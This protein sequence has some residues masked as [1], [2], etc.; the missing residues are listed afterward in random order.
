MLLASGCATGVTGDPSAISDNDALVQGEV[1]SDTG[2]Q[3]EYWFEYGPTPAYGSESVHGTLTAQPNT[4]HPVQLAIAGLQPG[5]DYHYRL[6]ARDSAQQGGPGCGEDRTLTTQ[7]VGCGDTVTEDLTLRANLLCPE[8]PGLVIGANDVTIN[9]AG[10]TVNGGITGS[11]GIDNR[12]GHDD[13]TVRNG[14]VVGWNIA[15]AAHDA[16][17][18]RVLNVDTS[19]TNTAIE[20]DGGQ[21]HLV[22]NSSAI[23]RLW[24]IDSRGSDAVE[25]AHSSAQGSLGGGMNLSGDGV[26]VVDNEVIFPG[27]AGVDQ[28]GIRLVG[29]V[30][31]IARNRVGGWALGSIVVAGS[32]NA[33]VRNEVFDSVMPSFTD[34]PDSVGDGIFVSAFSLRTLLRSNN[35]HDNEGDGIETQDPTSRLGGNTAVDN[36]DFGIE[37]VVGVTDLGGNTASGNGNPLQCINVACDP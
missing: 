2:G 17:R 18:A 4:L 14:S 36:G 34:P 24:G 3:V 19:A 31:R 5:G 15:I 9:L 1:I 8:M 29:S 12:A 35:V 21:G 37:A 16:L 28:H 30:A 20:F 7:S 26:R 11:F 32:D 23:G 27:G 6:C 22:R 33:L 10:H 13:V 25:V